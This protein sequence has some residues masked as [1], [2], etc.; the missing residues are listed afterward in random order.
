MAGMPLRRWFERLGNRL[1][2]PDSPRDAD[3]VQLSAGDSRHLNGLRARAKALS[4]ELLA[5]N[6]PWYAPNEENT[7]QLERTSR[8]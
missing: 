4:R 7:F 1:A 8:E 5:E 6:D 2:G 3:P